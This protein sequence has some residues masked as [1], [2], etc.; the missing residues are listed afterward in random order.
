LR[1]KSQAL[2]DGTGDSH[3]AVPRSPQR[4]RANGFLD[5]S[6]WACTTFSPRLSG[7]QS[8]V[9]VQGPMNSACHVMTS[10]S[11]LLLPKR[12]FSLS[13][14]LLL[15]EPQPRKTNGE[16]HHHDQNGVFY[17]RSC[18]ELMFT[19]QDCGSASHSALDK[20]RFLLFWVLFHVVATVLER[21]MARAT[22]A[23]L[24]QRYTALEK[25][26]ADALRQ[27]PT[28]DLAIADLKYRTV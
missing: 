16:D 9:D 2:D 23:Y 20:E 21:T 27:S 10:S 7:E 12:F 19:D 4:V 6:W 24:E 8:A 3:G 25:E 17:H 22:I 28:D 13:L 15:D 1:C 11:D 18:P 26:I 14:F 5:S